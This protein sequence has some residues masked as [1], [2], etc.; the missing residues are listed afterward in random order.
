[1]LVEWKRKWGET[2]DGKGR[3]AKRSECVLCLGGKSRVEGKGRE[4]KT[5]VTTKT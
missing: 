3:E 4:G 2:R 1:M 5:E